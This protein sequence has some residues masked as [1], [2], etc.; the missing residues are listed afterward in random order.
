MK[1]AARTA[2]LEAYSAEYLRYLGVAK[3]ARR[4]YAESVR[5]LEAATQEIL[6]TRL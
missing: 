6:D 1:R 5:L 4:S 3:P 2:S